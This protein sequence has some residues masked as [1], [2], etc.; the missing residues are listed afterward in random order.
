MSIFISTR[1]DGSGEQD[2]AILTIPLVCN[3]QLVNDSAEDKFVIEINV[4]IKDSTLQFE[5]CGIGV[6]FAGN[7]VWISSFWLNT[8][9]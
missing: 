6:K 9:V 1:V 3:V 2:H 7:H 5:D 4:E 8:T